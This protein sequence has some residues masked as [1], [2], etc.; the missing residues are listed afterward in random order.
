M[1]IEKR[2]YIAENGIAI[3]EH[4][5]T[6]EEAESCLPSYPNGKIQSMKGC[7]TASSFAEWFYSD[8]SDTKDLG[9]DAVFNLK[10]NGYFSI[11]IEDVFN[12]CGYIPAHICDLFEGE[13][14]DED[15]DVPPDELIFIDDITRV[16]TCSKCHQDF[17]GDVDFCNNCGN[18]VS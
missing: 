4:L 17:S 5:L 16:G 2:Y 6:K 13:E 8:E 18:C 1:V 14:A 3:N 7:L 10:T 11:T 9:S 15:D 12:D